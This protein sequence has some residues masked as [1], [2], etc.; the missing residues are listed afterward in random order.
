M[1]NVK[2]EI[3]QDGELVYTYQP[4]KQ[5]ATMQAALLSAWNWLYTEAL[6]NGQMGVQFKFEFDPHSLD[7]AKVQVDLVDF[8]ETFHLKG[9]WK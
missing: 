6:E 9:E 5:F 3:V 2:I 8:D 1:K 4:T 7:N